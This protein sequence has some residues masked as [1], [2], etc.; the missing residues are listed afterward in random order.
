MVIPSASDL[1]SKPHCARYYTDL[2]YL[3]PQVFIVS[4]MYSF[5]LKR[6]EGME[7][8]NRKTVTCNLMNNGQGTPAVLA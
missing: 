4:G 5:T 1:G 6:Q 8:G 3:K 2:V 7:K